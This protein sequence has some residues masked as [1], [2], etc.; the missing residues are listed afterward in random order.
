MYKLRFYHI[1]EEG[2]SYGTTDTF[3]DA[4]KILD[5]FPNDTVV[6]RYVSEES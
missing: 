1:N 4:V 6:I 3:E 2:D 5:T